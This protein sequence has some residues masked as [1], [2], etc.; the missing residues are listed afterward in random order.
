MSLVTHISV[1]QKTKKTEVKPSSLSSD[2]LGGFAFRSIGPALM[3]GRISD[4]VIDPSNENRWYVSAGSGGVWKTENAGAT[5]QSIFEGQGSYS[6]G[7]LALN[8]S[9]NNEI[10][11][12][13]GENV[14]GRHVGYGD[15]IYHSADGGKSWKNMGLKSSEHISK[16]VINPKNS[17]VM[18]VAAQGPLW[19][20]G[21]ERGVYKSTDGGKTWKKTLG[22]GDWVGATDLV[23]D[24]RN[25]DVLYAATWQRQRTVAGYMGGGPGTAIYKSIDGGENWTKLS[26][27][28]PSSNLGKIGLAISPQQPDVVYAAIEL[29]RRKGGVF[30]S[31]DQGASWNKMSDAVSGGTGPHY[32]QELYADPHQFDRIYLVSYMMFI[33]DNGGKDF[34]TMNENNK[35]VDNHAIAFKKNDP[36]YILV[37]TDGG[38]YESFDKTKS[39]KYMS[40]LPLTQFYK[41]AVDDQ[42]PFYNVYGGTQDN[43]SQMGPSRTQN[44]NGIRNSDWSIILGGDGHQPATEP[45]NPSIVYA[46]WQQGNLVRHDRSTGENVYIQPQPE[47]GEKTE[48]FNW[49]APILVSSHRPSRIYFA[50][51][52]LWKSE[53]RGDSWE[54]ISADLTTN[55]PRTQTPFFGKKQGWDNPWDVYAMSNYSS[56]TN[57]SESPKREGLLYVGTDDGNMHVTEDGGKSWRKI[58]FSSLPGLPLQAFVNDVKADVHDENTVYAVFDNHKSGDL[59]AYVYKSTDKGKT[60]TLITKGIAERTIT[61]RIVQDHVKKNLLFLGTEFGVYIS[62]TSGDSWMKFSA[63]LPTISVRDLA[64]QKRENDL[65]LATFGRGIY[66]L[67][68]FSALRLFDEESAK[69]EAFIATPRK[70]YWYQ[71]R[72]VLGEGGKASQGDEYFIAE[73]PDFGVQITYYMANALKSSKDK[74]KEQES[75]QLKAQKEVSIPDWMVLEKEEIEGDAQV[76]VAIYAPSGELIRMLEAKNGKGF[77]RITWNLRGKA[78]GTITPKNKDRKNQGPMVAPGIYQVQ[79]LKIE[80]QKCY[81]IGNKVSVEIEVIPGFSASIKGMNPNE[82][83]AFWVKLDQTYSD[84]ELFNEKVSQV[85]GRIET[86]HKAL[87]LSNKIMAEEFTELSSFSDDFLSIE[88][89]IYGSKIKQQIGEE[90]EYPTVYHYLGVVSTGVGD[91]TYGPTP[92]HL[93][94]MNAAVTLL[95][96][97]KKELELISNTLPSVEKKLRDAGIKMEL[98]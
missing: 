11:V 39:W 59:K 66:I 40:N 34:Y 97:A 42:L 26:N 51:Q 90:N 41:L 67:D 79:L 85:K 35:H 1:A 76:M 2:L 6:I 57:I 12:G 80:G 77:Q 56:I 63:G 19:S 30:K 83:A 94:C 48:R 89:I 64:I 71:Q 8:P 7:C 33:S 87:T 25:A 44:I 43:S 88:L 61:W 84:V 14:G 54:P 31:I 32:Y 92:T 3:S 96:K 37:G 24:P 49:D 72:S 81:E 18:W 22:E 69:K 91:A 73:N 47:L 65:V 98:D 9:N 27:G 60:W 86:M 78:V 29:D 93:K 15:G 82:T 5:W 13:T 95:E 55:T 38:V 17:Q 20:A 28:I 68:D 58:P 62:L 46:Q 50:S 74:R 53:N 10:W 4:I 45:A 16:I 70:G 23:I 75:E 36:N 52:R 21:G